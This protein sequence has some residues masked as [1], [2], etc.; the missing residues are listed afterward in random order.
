[1]SETAPEAQRVADLLDRLALYQRSRQQGGGLNPAQWEALRYLGRANRYS[2]SPGAL[3]RYLQTTKGTASQTIRALERKGLVRRSADPG[4]RRGVSLALTP[5]GEILLRRD[6]LAG[7]AEAVSSLGR[8]TQ[9]DLAAALAELL[10]DL[11]RRSGN[12][13]FGICR[14]CRFFRRNDARGESGGPHRCG[15]TGEP[16]SAPETLRICAEHELAA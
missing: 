2:R 14:T 12:R 15:L 16:L 1:M 8:S 13:S 7:I 11:Q 4:D 3:G 6:P 10:R 9:R 5:A